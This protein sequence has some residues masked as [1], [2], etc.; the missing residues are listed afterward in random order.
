MSPW[1]QHKRQAAQ[2]KEKALLLKRAKRGKRV[3]KR[4]RGSKRLEHVISTLPLKDLRRDCLSLTDFLPSPLSSSRYPLSRVVLLFV[5]P[6][7]PG[8]RGKICEGASLQDK[9]TERT[10]PVRN[11]RSHCRAILVMT[12]LMNT[13]LVDG[14]FNGT[15]TNSKSESP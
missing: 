11:S 4:S 9:A 13:I 10:R 15:Q 2:E 3:F 6:P 7:S 5:S 14:S 8:G 12:A 1:K